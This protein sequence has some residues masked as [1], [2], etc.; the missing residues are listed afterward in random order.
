MTRSGSKAMAKGLSN[1]QLAKLI[2]KQADVQA[3][4]SIKLM[5]DA[6]SAYN[7]LPSDSALDVTADLSA[8]NTAIDNTC[9]ASFT[10]DGLQSQADAYKA[11]ADA[12]GEP[13]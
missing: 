5:K 8:V 4:L 2:T 3:R 10:A 7:A 1:R 12:A 9:R 13:A 11:A 6:N